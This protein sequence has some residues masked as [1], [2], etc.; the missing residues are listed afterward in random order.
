MRRPLQTQISELEE[1][2]AQKHA[3]LEQLKRREAGEARKRETRRKIVAGAVVLKAAEGDP[4][5]AALLHRILD[6]G[7]V[8][9]RDRAL[10][11]LA[12]NEDRSES[13]GSPC[14]EKRSAPAPGR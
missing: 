6:R 4:Q 3:R 13:E 1:R 9:A 8:A 5:L 11:G 2:L 7:V 12:A 10:F 14:P